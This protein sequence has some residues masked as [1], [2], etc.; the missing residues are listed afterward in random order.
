VR[1]LLAESLR[2]LLGIVA[3]GATR[4]PLLERLDEVDAG[5][6]QAREFLALV[7][8]TPQSGVLYERHLALL[9]TLDHL[10]RLTEACREKSFLK[11]V[12]DQHDVAAALGSLGR[13]ADLCLE[14]LDG[15]LALP[16]DALAA[17]SQAIAEL[18]RRG[19]PRL[20]MAAA[21]GELTPAKG[22]KVLET[23]RWIDRLA[24]HVWRAGHHLF[25]ADP[26]SLPNASLPSA[27]DPGPSEG[28]A[29]ADET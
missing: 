16:G 13:A 7:R 28:A 8:S 11:Q 23:V 19:R 27:P 15:A 20:L 17:Q 22:S 5:L 4:P 9:H 26:A 1:G 6:A 2:C 3:P 18:R 10:D 21:G 24:F 12:R 14:A 25:P 29:P